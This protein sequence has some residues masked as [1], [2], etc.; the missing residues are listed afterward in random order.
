MFMNVQDRHSCGA[1]PSLMF[2]TNLCVESD[3]QGSG[4]CCVGQHMPWVFNSFYVPSSPELFAHHCQQR[5]L[6]CEDDPYRKVNGQ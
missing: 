2:T 1:Q 5:F 6:I 4:A 3:G